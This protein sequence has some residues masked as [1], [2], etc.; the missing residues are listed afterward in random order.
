M[1]TVA[2]LRRAFNTECNM[3]KELYQEA[4][5]EALDLY[6]NGWITNWECR[7]MLIALY[8]QRYLLVSRPL[9]LTPSGSIQCV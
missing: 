4:R 6:N 5:D 2:R 8:R 9:I 3:E 1:L 7:D